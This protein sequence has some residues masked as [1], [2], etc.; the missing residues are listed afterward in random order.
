MFPRCVRSSQAA[1][2]RLLRIISSGRINCN[3]SSRRGE[4]SALIGR[5]IIRRTAW[6]SRGQP[7]SLVGDGRGAAT[8]RG[9]AWRA[10]QL[11]RLV[12]GWLRHLCYPIG[13]GP[14]LS[15]RGRGR[16]RCLLHTLR[17]VKDMTVVLGS[18]GFGSRRTTARCRAIRATARGGTPRPSG[19]A[20]RRN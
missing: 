14:D 19:A 6:C 17:K 7:G 4:P 2:L 15:V 1:F 3:V 12:S 11:L 13:C 20:C 5:C 18:R 10:S 8:A 9:P 16:L